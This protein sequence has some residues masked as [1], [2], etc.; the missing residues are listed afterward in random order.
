MSTEQTPLSIRGNLTLEEVPRYFNELERHPS[1][2]S[3]VDLSAV[4]RSDSSALAF[5]LEIKARA[6]ASN[7]TVEF[8]SPPAALLTLARLSGVSVLLDWPNHQGE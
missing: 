8:K 5:L 4:E 6:R 3:S 7:V 1:V 2:P